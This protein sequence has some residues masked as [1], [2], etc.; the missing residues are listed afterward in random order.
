MTGNKDM[1]GM[2]LSI[3]RTRTGR[4]GRIIT[5]IRRLVRLGIMSR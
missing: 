2:G 3:M 4:L 5:R 1:L